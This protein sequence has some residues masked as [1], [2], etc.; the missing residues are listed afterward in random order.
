MARVVPE[1]VRLVPVEAQA[2]ADEALI[3]EAVAFRVVLATR[4]PVPFEVPAQET[5]NSQSESA[6]GATVLE[7]VS[8]TINF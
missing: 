7:V 4:A 6:V 8:Q 5:M 2:V 3:A 1:V